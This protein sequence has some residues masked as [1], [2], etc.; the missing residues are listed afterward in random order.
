[1]K[2]VLL[3][4]L[5]GIFM[6]GCCCQPL[7]YQPIYIVAEREKPVEPTPPSEMCTLS[8]SITP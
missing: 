4:L 7:P 6:N 2:R 1:M 3:L 8:L 5:F